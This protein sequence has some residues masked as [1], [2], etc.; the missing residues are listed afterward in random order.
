MKFRGYCWRWRRYRVQ[1]LLKS[2][3]KDKEYYFRG[4]NLR[5]VVGDSLRYVRLCRLRIISSI[6][7]D[8]AFESFILAIEYFTMFSSVKNYQTDVLR[9]IVSSQISSPFVPFELTNPASIYILGLG[10]DSEFILAV[11]WW[12]I[13]GVSEPFFFLF[14]WW[15]QAIPCSFFFLFYT[16]AF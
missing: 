5:D 8:I 14:C 4:S 2:A 13:I 10:K 12:K 11:I 9:G 6:P 3:V 16:S 1:N 15:W 7:S